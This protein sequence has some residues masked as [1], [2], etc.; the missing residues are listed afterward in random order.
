MSRHGVHALLILRLVVALPAQETVAT[1]RLEVGGHLPQVQVMVNGKGPFTFGIDTGSGAPAVVMPALIQQL[2][3][4]ITG[5]VTLGDGTASGGQKVPVLMIYSLNVAGV[6]FDD[7]QAVQFAGPIPPTVDGI[8]GFKLFRA[9]LFTLDYPGQ[10]F[11]LAQGSLPAAD[12]NEIIPFRM[13][14]D[15]PVIELGI[16]SRKIDAHIDS[17]GRGLDLPEK[18]ARDLKFASPPVVLGKGHSVANDFVIK[19]A[20]LTT[21]IRL[22]R[23]TFSHPFV[24]INPLFPIANFGAFPLRNFAVTFDQKNKLVR[25]VAATK[26]VV[27]AGPTMMRDPQPQPP[28]PQSH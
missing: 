18:F 1:A 3:L 4:P 28:P 2:K 14:F 10:R 15:I 7:L 11:I 26:I 13:P 27:L 17:G 23:Y 25:F 19:G 24:E 12:G 22:G 21:D 16:G 8:L 6:E 9:Y 5:E 20:K